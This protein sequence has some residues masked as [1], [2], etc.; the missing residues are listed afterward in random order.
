MEFPTA[1]L[2]GEQGRLRSA[3]ASAQSNKRLCF[4]HIPSMSPGKSKKS[5]SS[6]LFEQM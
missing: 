2:M 6:D 3:G 1:T 4:S 5:A